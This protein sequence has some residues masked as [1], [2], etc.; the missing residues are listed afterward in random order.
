LTKSI[1]NAELTVTRPE[2]CYVDRGYKGHGADEFISG[3]HRNVRP[4]IKKELNRRSAIEAVIGYLKT[5][6]ID[7]LVKKVKRT[8]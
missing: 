6:A 7:T 8:P 1:K 3:Q 5:E 4:T 2:C